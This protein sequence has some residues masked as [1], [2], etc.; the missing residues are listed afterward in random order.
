MTKSSFD[1]LN[2]EDWNK[3]SPKDGALRVIEF[4]ETVARDSSSD[5]ALGPE[6][7]KTLMLAMGGLRPAFEVLIVSIGAS[8]SNVVSYGLIWRLMAHSFTVGQHVGFLDKR[9][10]KVFENVKAWSA[11][12]ARVAK[13]VLRNRALDDAIVDEGKAMGKMAI[14]IECANLIRPGV[15]RRLKLNSEEK[16]PSKWQ[17]KARLSKIKIG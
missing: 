4:M 16:Y 12:A 10:K 9:A 3:L 8:P 15:Q 7:K 5:K 2:I 11:N 13:V 6:E 14:S 1:E 17:I